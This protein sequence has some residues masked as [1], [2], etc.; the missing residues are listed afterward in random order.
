MGFASVMKDLE[1][2]SDGALQPL[3]GFNVGVELGQMSVLAGAFAL[4]GATLLALVEVRKIEPS[5]NVPKHMELAR[6]LASVAI[7]GVGAYWTIER[8]FT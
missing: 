1:L 8:I 3:V 6:K 4:A 2:P 7:A 5:F